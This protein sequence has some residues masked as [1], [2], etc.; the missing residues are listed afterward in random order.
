L[1][2]FNPFRLLIQILLLSYVAAPTSRKILY[3]EL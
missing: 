1:L 2:E 3:R